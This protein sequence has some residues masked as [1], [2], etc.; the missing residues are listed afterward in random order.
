MQ[1]YIYLTCVLKG[2]WKKKTLHCRFTTSADQFH[3]ITNWKFG[4]RRNRYTGRKKCWFCKLITKRNIVLGVFTDSHYKVLLGK[5]TLRIPRAL[6]KSY[7]SNRK[8]CV[9]VRKLGFATRDS[10]CPPREGVGCFLFKASTSDIV[11]ISPSAKLVIYDDDKKRFLP[12]KITVN[13]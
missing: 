8:R 2:F 3:L 12:L 9:A 10:G 6:P 4:F 1:A 7:L 13:I 5:L 11:K